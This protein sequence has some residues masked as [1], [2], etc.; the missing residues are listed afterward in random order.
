MIMGI[1][2]GLSAEFD[3]YEVKMAEKKR[4]KKESGD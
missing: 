1:F 2:R 4:G 3:S